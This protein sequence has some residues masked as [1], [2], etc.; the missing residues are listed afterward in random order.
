MKKYIIT[1]IEQN[2]EDAISLKEMIEKISFNLIKV[3][4]YVSVEH[5][6]ERFES[7]KPNAVVLNVSFKNTALFNFQK[8]FDLNDIKTLFIAS[9]D[10]R[11]QLFSTVGSATTYINKP[12]VKAEIIALINE[13][14]DSNSKKNVAAGVINKNQ[15]TITSLDKVDF[16][17]TNDIL[18]CVADG[19]YTTFHMVDGKKIV[20][21]KNIGSYQK[22]LNENLFYRVHHGYIINT[23]YLVGVVKREGAFC[24]LINDVSIPIAKRKQ[25]HFNKFIKYN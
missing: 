12:Y 5:A 6:L 9:K 17:D 20:S 23:K 19:K 24:K 8:L 14:L 7:E 21:S 3:N 1:I 2:I 4:H 10:N 25:S 22:L 13:L 11:K 18:F 15:V 16:V